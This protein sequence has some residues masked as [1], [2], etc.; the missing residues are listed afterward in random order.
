MLNITKATYVF[1]YV[2]KNQD[3]WAF[4][5]THLFDLL[6]ILYLIQYYL[7]LI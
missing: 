5:V 4:I 7:D 6:F 1:C 2:D 3:T